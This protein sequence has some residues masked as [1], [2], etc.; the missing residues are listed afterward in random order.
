MSQLVEGKLPC[1]NCPSSDAYHLYDDGH[2]Y[3]FSCKKT[4]FIKETDKGSFTY[5]Y[6]PY[7]GLKK[8]TLE[9]YKVLTRIN[10]EGKPVAVVYPYTNAAKVRHF[11]KVFYSIGDMKNADLCG[12]DKFSAASARAITI[13]EGEDDMLAAY[14]MLGSKYPVVSVSSSSNAKRD[15]ARRYEYLN[16]FD[17]IY[18]CFDNDDV[19]A[20]AALE[21]AALFDFNKVYHV[22]LSLKDAQQYH[23]A[24]KAKDFASIW[25]N[26]K[27]FIPEGIVSSFSEIDQIIDAERTHGSSSYPFP[28]LQ[29]MTYGIRQGEVI[30]LTA[31]SGIGKTEIIRAIEYH[32]IKTTDENIGIIH[33]E[34]EKERSIKGLVSYE[35][36]HPAHLPNSC[37]SK[38]DIKQAYRDLVVR[39]DRIHLYSHFGSDDPDTILDTVRFLAGS[40]GCRYIFLDHITMVVSGSNSDDERKKLDYIS[41]R[42]AMMVRELDFTLF[43]VSH[44]NSSGETRGSKNIYN[45]ADLAIR[46]ERNVT[47]ETS[48]ERNKTY[49]TVNK[50]RFASMTGPA[51]VLTFDPKTF[52]VKE[53]PELGFPPLEGLNDN[54]HGT[55]ILSEAIL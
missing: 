15:C 3:C 45:V 25:W 11:P 16:S 51:G 24:N 18:L 22:K 54:I 53:T 36:G 1:P 43:M 52:I 4:T 12:W 33:L 8:E 26:A 32:L 2:G 38:E 27:R 20:K 47:A 34:E 17:K 48:A 49:L 39:D 31:F 42:L 14:E 19:G 13:T 40:C 6:L 29:E 9:F 28:T 21:V 55:T 30:L 35:I 46:L 37:V 41:T 10:L 44:V 5:E 7:R 23:E 50:N